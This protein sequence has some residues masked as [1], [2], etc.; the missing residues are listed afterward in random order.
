MSTAPIAKTT[1]AWMALITR[2]VTQGD[3]L[4]TSRPRD[5]SHITAPRFPP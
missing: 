1:N 4:A 5:L 2:Q 3:K